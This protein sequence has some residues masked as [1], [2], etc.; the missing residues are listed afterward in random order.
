MSQRIVSGLWLV[1]AV[2]NIS[3]GLV[4][5]SLASQLLITT[6]QAL[7]DYDR[8]AASLLLES[9]AESGRF[10]FFFRFGNRSLMMRAVGRRVGAPLYVLGPWIFQKPRMLL[11]R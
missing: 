9:A 3:L 2:S 8:Q 11:T 6:R 1:H 4:L 5:F 7:V 10:A